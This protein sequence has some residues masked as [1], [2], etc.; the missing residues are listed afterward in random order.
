MPIRSERP[1]FDLETAYRAL[2]WS[3]VRQDS[4][5]TTSI[6]IIQDTVESVEEKEHS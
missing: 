5:D 2:I 1:A 4:D 6:R 3:F